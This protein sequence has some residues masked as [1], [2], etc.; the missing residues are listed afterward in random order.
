[1]RVFVYYLRMQLMNYETMLHLLRSTQTSA[2]AVYFCEVADAA[3][4]GADDA[5]AT[6]WKHIN[7]NRRR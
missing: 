7:D 2:D 4:V 6:K 1:M 3:V 5:E